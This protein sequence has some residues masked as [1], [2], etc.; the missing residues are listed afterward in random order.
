MTRKNLLKTVAIGAGA[1]GAFALVRH[2]TK[3]GGSHHAGFGH[4]S[5][6]GSPQ[7]YYR[8]TNPYGTYG[9]APFLAQQQDPQYFYETVS[10]YGAYGQPPFLA[11]EPYVRR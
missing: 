5:D 9:Q 2:L 11:H 3:T 8:N 6:F 1:L 4:G 7:W 10:P